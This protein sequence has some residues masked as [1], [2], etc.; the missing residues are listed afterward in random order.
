[1]LDQPKHRQTPRE[2]ISFSVVYIVDLYV[3]VCNAHISFEYL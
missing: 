2:S 3:V 1:M